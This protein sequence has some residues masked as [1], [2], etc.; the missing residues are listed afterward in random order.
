MRVG[1]L[2][3]SKWLNGQHFGVLMKQERQ[4]HLC[5]WR[6]YWTGDPVVYDFTLED[7]NDL[8]VLCK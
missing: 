2:V 3:R 8:E 6:V 7:E 1:T 5:Y 4:N